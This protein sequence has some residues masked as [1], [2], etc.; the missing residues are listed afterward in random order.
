MSESQRKP[1]LSTILK[2]IRE[3]HYD[4]NLSE[5]EM[6]VGE[7]RTAILE[8]V[9]KLV[10]DTLGANYIVT[11]VQPTPQKRAPVLP[12]GPFR[13]DGGGDQMIYPDEE[14]I[15]AEKL[16]LDEDPL[17]KDDESRSPV[18]GS[19]DDLPEGADVEIANAGAPDV[20]EFLTQLGS[21]EHPAT[22]GDTDVRTD[23]LEL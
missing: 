20:S 12:L 19:L 5:I 23:T 7:R 10:K 16:S 8:E 2:L 9:E 15:A 18:F 17:S 22:E 1:R 21:Q 6:G 11:T 13:S 4:K 14:V 3:G